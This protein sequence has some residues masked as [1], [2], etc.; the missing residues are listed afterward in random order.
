[1]QLFF[2]KFDPF[3]TALL[4]L[5]EVAVMLCLSAKNNLVDREYYVL[6]LFDCYGG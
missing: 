6:L 2:F 4:L 3:L 1:M 5:L